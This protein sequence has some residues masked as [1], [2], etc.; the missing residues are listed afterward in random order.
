MRP[1]IKHSHTR[2]VLHGG[3]AESVSPLYE[4]RGMKMVK[5]N[6]LGALAAV[7]GLLQAYLGERWKPQPNP[8][9]R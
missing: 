4:R 2:L 3:R 7:V 8:Q 1:H 5:A 6:P 9:G